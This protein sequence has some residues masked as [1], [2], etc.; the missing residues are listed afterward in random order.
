METRAHVTKVTAAASFFQRKADALPGQDK[1]LDL[2]VP[3][4]TFVASL[5]FSSG[6]YHQRRA[7]EPP[8]FTG[9]KP[10]A[11]FGPKLISVPLQCLDVDASAV[12]GPEPAASGFVL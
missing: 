5:L 6:S 1:F 9:P 12:N 2:F 4:V 10:F 3:S 7:V 8:F 11:R